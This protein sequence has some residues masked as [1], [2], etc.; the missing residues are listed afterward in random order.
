V[1][2]G[3]RTHELPGRCGADLALG[4]EAIADADGD[5]AHAGALDHA[6]VVDPAK[7]RH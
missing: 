4:G 2:A 1:A 3:D 6:D 7:S 5:E